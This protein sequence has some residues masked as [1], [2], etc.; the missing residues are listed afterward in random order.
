MTD[1][2]RIRDSITTG[3]KSDGVVYKYDV[4]LPI[5]AFY[6]LV[7]IMRVRTKHL[8]TRCVGYGH[9][10]DGNLHLNITSPI[11]APKL[12]GIIEPF[13][14]KYAAD[15]KGSISAE[16]GLG[17]MKADFIHYSKSQEAIA[18]MAKVKGILNFYST[19]FII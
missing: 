19:H 6:E 13:V 14:Y 18:L 4:S 1:I 10:G 9:L 2:W 5:S 11:H 17:I 8:A 3:L 12:L 7:N 15:A 16:H